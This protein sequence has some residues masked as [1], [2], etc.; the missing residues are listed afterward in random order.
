M[1][2]LARLLSTGSSA[3]TWLEARRELAALITEFGPTSKTSPVQ[4]AAYP[5]TR[6]R[7]DGLWTLTPDVPMDRVKPLEEHAVVGQLE[8]TL[9][10]WLL[11]HPHVALQAVHELAG[12]NFAPT[13]A[14]DVLAA[15]GLDADTLQL[16]QLDERSGTDSTPATGTSVGT[17]AAA[18]VLSDDARRSPTERKRSAAWRR[19]VLTAWDRLCAFCGFDGQLLHAPVGLEAAHVRWF[20]FS[21]PDEADNGLALCSLHHKLFDRGVLGLTTQLR[22]QVSAAFTARSDAARS[23][24]ELHQRPLA[25]D[26]PGRVPPAAEHLRWHQRQIFKAPALS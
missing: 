13:V 20:Q 16:P 18:G 15:I 11:A 19:E 5:F 12:T 26:R 4:A 8:P 3:I 10:A 2:A 9:Q 6:L 7:S 1:L 24:Y 14:P 21:G 23:V 17:S 22:V 25:M